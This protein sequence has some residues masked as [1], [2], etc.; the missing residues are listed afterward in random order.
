MPS[1]LA[2]QSSAR[3]AELLARERTHMVEFL[4]E[5]ATFD[6]RQLWEEMGHRSLFGYLNRE[7][8]M[9][10]AAAH[11]RKAAANL[12]QRFPE[13][14][15]PLRDGRLCISS[16]AELAKV[17]T[18]ENREQVLPRFLSRSSREAKAMSAVMAPTGRRAPLRAVEA[19]RLPAEPAFVG[20]LAQKPEL[21][22]PHPDLAEPLSRDRYRLHVTLTKAEYQTILAARVAHNRRHPGDS[23]G[24]ALA[25]A[26]GLLLKDQRRRSWLSR[27]PPDL[28]LMAASSGKKVARTT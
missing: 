14:I 27:A 10:K 11:S 17:I 18:E 3:L 28:E 13:V 22:L 21:T 19:P 2:Q 24:A 26:S 7:L 1:H 25:A 15:E 6:A 23:L 5:L 12:V 4:L 16:M 9:S 8:R 20:T